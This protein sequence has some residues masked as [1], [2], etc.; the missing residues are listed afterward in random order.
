MIEIDL[1]MHKIK[2]SKVAALTLQCVP[3]SLKNTG[4]PKEIWGEEYFR[5]K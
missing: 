2:P 3:L 1:Y 4:H 5:S